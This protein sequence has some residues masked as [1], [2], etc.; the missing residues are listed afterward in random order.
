MLYVVTGFTP[1]RIEVRREPLP[2]HLNNPDLKHHDAS[3]DETKMVTN[4][5]QKMTKLR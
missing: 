4:Q 3:S 1:A 5:P 2:R